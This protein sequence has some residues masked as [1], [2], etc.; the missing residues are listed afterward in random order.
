M[1]QEM[2]QAV[3]P[4]QFPP[5]PADG[6]PSRRP[7]KPLGELLAGSYDSEAQGAK[8]GDLFS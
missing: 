8:I 3:L 1:P 4:R 2:D 6:L 5:A 7:A